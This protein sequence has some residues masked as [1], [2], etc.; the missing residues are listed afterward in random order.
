MW[1]ALVFSCLYGHAL[2]SYDGC[3]ES[4]EADGD[5]WAL[6]VI[7]IVVTSICHR[8]GRVAGARIKHW[9][10]AHKCVIVLLNVG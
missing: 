3:L 10:L 2:A 1:P 7:D 8:L 6:A 9:P 5:A 4:T